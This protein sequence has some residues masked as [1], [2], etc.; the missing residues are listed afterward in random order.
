MEQEG[1]GASELL[2]RVETAETSQDEGVNTTMTT[3]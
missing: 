2:W 1:S 3:D